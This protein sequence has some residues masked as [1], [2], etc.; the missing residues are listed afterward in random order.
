MDSRNSDV[1]VVDGPDTQLTCTWLHRCL[2]HVWVKILTDDLSHRGS[3]GVL[4][5]I[6]ETWLISLHFY[7]LNSKGDYTV[8]P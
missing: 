3:H 5:V 4:I 7:C 2:L 8:L 6:G 1:A